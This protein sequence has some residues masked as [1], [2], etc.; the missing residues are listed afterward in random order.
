MTDTGLLELEICGAE[1]PGS[2]IKIHTDGSREIIGQFPL[3][4]DVAVDAD[5]SVYVTYGSIL[6][7]FAG[8]GALAKL[9]YGD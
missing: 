1:V 8:G 6:P 3:V 9:T 2:V 7:A 5:G 4:G